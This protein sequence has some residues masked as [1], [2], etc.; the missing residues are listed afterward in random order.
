MEYLT[1]KNLREF[2]NNKELDSYQDALIMVFC[3]NEGTRQDIPLE[4]CFDLTWL[5]ENNFIDIN[6]E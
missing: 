1:L 3:C 5:E 4:G 6:I 2:V